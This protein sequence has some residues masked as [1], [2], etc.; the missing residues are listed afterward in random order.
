MIVD[1]HDIR[2]TLI[3]ASISL[4]AGT[5][6]RLAFREIPR[7]VN[8]RIFIQLMCFAGQAMRNAGIAQ[9]CS[10]KAFLVLN[11]S[12]GEAMRHSRPLGAVLVNSE[13]EHL[14]RGRGGGLGILPAASTVGPNVINDR[15]L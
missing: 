1:S 7:R 11:Q 2:E 8:R 14:V 12:G 15:A 5:A 13:D 4:S 3:K 10:R 6:E 9:Y